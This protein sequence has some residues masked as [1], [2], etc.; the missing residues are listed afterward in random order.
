MPESA[1]SSPGPL[2]RRR[3]RSCLGWSASAPA[4]LAAGPL[5]EWGELRLPGLAALSPPPQ[6]GAIRLS[7]NEN[8]Y[9]MCEA[10]RARWMEVLED[11]NR[12]PFRWESE[13]IAALAVHHGVSESNLVAGA[14][15]TE[16][17]RMCA[18]AWLS[19][20]RGLVE[21][22]PTFETLGFY[23]RGAGVPVRSIALDRQ[24]RHDLDA[25]ADAIDDATAVVYVCNPGNPSSTLVPQAQLDAFLDAIPDRVLVLVDEAYHDFVD[26]PDYRTQ[27]PRALSSD[28]VI[29]IRTF[30]KVFGMAGMRVGYAIAGSERIGELQ[31]PRTE[32]SVSVPAAVCA[33]VSI[34]DSAYPVEQKRLNAEA[35]SVLTDGLDEMGI[36]YWQSQTNFVMAHLGRPMMP[37]NRAMAARGVHVGRLFPALPQGLRISIGTP[38]QMHRCVEE[39][40]RAIA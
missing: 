35:R 29:V 33:T 1:L 31:A 8:P 24:G 27:I 4:L 2:T 28:N 6:P 9:G 14:G 23:A 5:P 12:Y 19:P 17:L 13:L 34:R 11:A 18:A 22:N 20:E 15:S 7:S 10:A 40:R 16:I 32:M 3:L 38:E 30:S 26:A 37:V 25:M 21:A 39:L 36:E